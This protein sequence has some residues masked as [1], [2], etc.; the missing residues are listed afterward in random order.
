MADEGGLFSAEQVCK[1]AHITE[2]QLRHWARDFYRPEH[3][4]EDGGPF[5]YIYSFRDVVSLRTIGVLRNKHH[6]PLPAL[7]RAGAWLAERHDTPWAS[8]RLRI[9]GKG[10]Y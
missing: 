8:L 5:T 7:K 9:S 1:L 6:I 10:L 4:T 2:R 3:L